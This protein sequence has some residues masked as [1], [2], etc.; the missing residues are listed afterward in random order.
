MKN[1]IVTFKMFV[2]LLAIVLYSSCT[3]IDKNE[4]T[5]SDDVRISTRGSGITWDYP[6][7]PGMESWNSLQTEDDRI[8]ALQVPE[9]ILATLSSDEVVGLCIE[10]PAFFLFTA[11]NTPQDGF[12]VMSSRYNILRHILLR[13]DLGGNLIAA[14][15]DADLFGFRTLPYSNEFW[16]IKLL[17]FE[18]LLSQKEILQS[19]TPEE[20][21]EL[22]LEARSKFIEKTSNESFSSLPGLLFSLKIM[23]TIL[24]VEKYPEFLVSPQKEKIIQFINTGWWFEDIPPI[25]EIYRIADYYINEKNDTVN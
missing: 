3:E 10:L 1:T 21:L 16:S 2:L 20:K 23:A 9:S 7:K 13:N 8:T 18:L 12:D 11:W 4:A 24:D 14:Y 6:V 25:D 22:I 19:M 15:K 5:V 17:Y